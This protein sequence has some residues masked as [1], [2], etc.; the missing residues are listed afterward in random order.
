MNAKTKITIEVEGEV[1]KTIKLLAN[2]RHKGKLRPAT[3]EVLEESLEKGVLKDIKEM[4]D[5]DYI[6]CK[7]YLIQ[8]VNV[9]RY[10]TAFREQFFKLKMSWRNELIRFLANVAP[11]YKLV[12]N[13]M[14]NKKVDLPAMHKC[15][16]SPV[17]NLSCYH[18]NELYPNKR[19]LNFY[20]TIKPTFGPRNVPI[21]TYL[22][23]NNISYAVADGFGFEDHV[24]IARKEHFV[25]K[26]YQNKDGNIMFN[27]ILTVLGLTE[28]ID[29]V[30]L[31]L[32]SINKLAN[33]FQDKW[34]VIPN[35]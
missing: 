12:T 30:K 32:T 33:H 18:I 31:S 2:L 21:A 15:Y 19:F 20:L 27:E 6:Y 13:I 35:N 7:E 22:K 29:A 5:K 8:K 3:I 4:L 16:I 14:L 10:P 23:K 1:E 9:V 24:W 34:E 25:K 11:N 28:E 26:Q 17:V